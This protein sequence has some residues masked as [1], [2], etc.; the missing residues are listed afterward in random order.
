MRET[1]WFQLGPSKYMDGAG[2][3]FEW[4]DDSI[5]VTSPKRVSLDSLTFAEYEAAKHFPCGWD[6]RDAKV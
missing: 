1:D 4:R 2:Y 5:Y 6:E 3:T